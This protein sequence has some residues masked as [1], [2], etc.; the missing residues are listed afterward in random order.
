MND[1]FKK[2]FSFDGPDTALKNATLDFLSSLWPKDDER[3]EMPCESWDRD[4]WDSAAIRFLEGWLM[5]EGMDYRGCVH[6][7]HDPALYGAVLKTARDEGYMPAFYRMRT[8]KGDLDSLTMFG[9]GIT[10]AIPVDEDGW[11]PL[12]YRMRCDDPPH[13]I[14]EEARDAI[15]ENALILTKGCFAFG[16][17]ADPGGLDALHY[18][19]NFIYTLVEEGFL[20]RPFALSLFNPSEEN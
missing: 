17:L 18:E 7:A 9:D 1:T 19:I 16:K 2:F 15:P 8:I 3:G 11:S 4:Q 10:V 12:A 5:K 6:C 20:K 13:P 14:S